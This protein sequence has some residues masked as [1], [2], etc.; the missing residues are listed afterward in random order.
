LVAFVVAAISLNNTVN[1]AHAQPI[2][3]RVKPISLSDGYAITGGFI[4]TDGTIGSLFAGNIVDYEVRVTGIYPF[5]FT[6]YNL[7]A[8]VSIQGNVFS[9]VDG[10]HVPIDSMSTAADTQGFGFIAKIEDIYY[11]LSWRNDYEIWSYPEVGSYTF[12]SS[13]ISYTSIDP[14]IINGWHANSGWGKSPQRAIS[15]AF[16]PEPSSSAVCLMAVVICACYRKL[17]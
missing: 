15:V 14:R 11:G 3:Y 12:D 7:A 17:R 16:V 6:P 4:E 2:R 13:S 10:I 5:V 1:S 8:Q 9:T